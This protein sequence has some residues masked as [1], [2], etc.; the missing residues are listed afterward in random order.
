MS[1]TTRWALGALLAL[2]LGANARLES[3]YDTGVAAA[4]GALSDLQTPSQIAQLEGK[5]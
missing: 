2:L 4:A 5:K 3:Q 1:T